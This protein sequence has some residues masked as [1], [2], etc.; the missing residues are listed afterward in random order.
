MPTELSKLRCRVENLR[1]YDRITESIVA[2]LYDTR[3]AR[4]VKRVTSFILLLVVSVKLFL[5]ASCKQ[6]IG[7]WFLCFILDV[8]F[9]LYIFL[10]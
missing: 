7:N 3:N 1:F 8:H 10:F 2:H 4:F 9:S 6:F 5:I